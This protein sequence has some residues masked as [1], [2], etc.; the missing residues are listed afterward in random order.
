[1]FKRISSPFRKV[2]PKKLTFDTRAPDY[3]EY[4]LILPQRLFTNK[5]ILAK[6]QRC[7]A[8]RY[9]EDL[10]ENIVG[11]LH[12]VSHFPYGHPKCDC[13]ELEHRVSDF[14]KLNSLL[15]KLPKENMFVPIEDWDNKYLQSKV[16]ELIDIMMYLGA[17][18]VQYNVLN[19]SSTI[20]SQGMN[21]DISIYGIN[22][23]AGMEIET[24]ETSNNSISGKIIFQK[25]SVN[26]DILKDESKFHYL[27]HNHDWIH[28]VNQRLISCISSYEI[29]TQ[30]SESIQI[31]KSARI[32]LKKLSV[33]LH[34]NHAHSSNLTIKMSAKFIEFD[35]NDVTMSP[36]PSSDSSDNKIRLSDGTEG[37]C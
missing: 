19:K 10:K 7:L 23:G 6:I 8:Q 24:G 28:M 5:G 17:K 21:S 37:A 1:M 4:I 12:I 30:I 22:I 36:K 20:D 2:K 29:R 26:F 32:S 33:S 13:C 11:K 25:P 31:N 18:E 9:I 14:I 15:V 34:D 16:S 35:R 3:I 27:S